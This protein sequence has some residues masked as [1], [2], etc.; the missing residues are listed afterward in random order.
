MLGQDDCGVA[1]RS[2]SVCVDEG[3]A[4]DEVAAVR[5]ELEAFAGEVFES[6]ARNDQPRWGQVYVR[7]L[8]TDGTRKSVEPM[9]ARPGEDGNRQAR[10]HFVAAGPWDPSHIRARLV[11]KMEAVIRPAAVVFDDT[12]FL[13]DGDAPT[14]LQILLAPG[15]APPPPATATSP[16]S[17]RPDQVLPGLAGTSNRPSVLADS[18]PPCCGHHHHEEDTLRI[19]G[20]IPSIGDGC[21]VPDGPWPGTGRLVG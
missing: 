4:P 13:T 14:C 20:Q 11:W 21:I 18:R 17:H 16:P 6:F 7:R 3:V 19:S 2:D 10:A 12:G 1:C 9:A 8:L 5:G 15:P